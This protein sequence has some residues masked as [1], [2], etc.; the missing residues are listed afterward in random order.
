MADITGRLN[1]GGLVGW[2]TK[3]SEDS[4]ISLNQ[5]GNKG[6]VKSS[7]R[8]GGL[9]GCV[10]TNENMPITI[11]ECTNNGTVDGVSDSGGLIGSFYNNN[12]V[13]VS[14]VNSTNTGG[15]SNKNK[16]IGGFVGVFDHNPNIT[17]SVFG[18]TNT[19]TISGVSNAGGFFGDLF[20]NTHISLTLSDVMN[21]GPISGNSYSGGFVGIIQSS[22]P[23][24]STSLVIRN[25]V[26]KG[27]ITSSDII[28]CGIF[29][30]QGSTIFN[31]H[32]TVLNSI[33]KGTINV[34]NQGYGIANDVTKAH[35][36][37]SMGTING[38][39]TMYSFWSSSSEADELF[40][41]KDTCRNCTDG[42]PFRTTNKGYY[43]VDDTGE[44]VDDLLNDNAANALYGMTWTKELDLAY[45][46]FVFIGEPF[47][48]DYNIPL[49]STVER[50]AEIIG[51]DT[52]K[53]V[54]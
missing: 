52:N 9:I 23:T 40:V 46:V 33:N 10:T 12:N 41:L 47:G 4:F 44:Y 27:T 50:A 21:T 25:G 35:N 30:T 37:V 39:H 16:D 26:N 6:Y 31:T 15:V 42:K 48:Q 1:V 22:D 28:G 34:N 49:G 7:G 13:T 29:C 14:F 8:S 32:T 53:Y 45:V 5:C 19:G 38:Q 18:S 24:R 36:I 51:L 43:Q 2:I 20:D 3:G 54:Q 11:S 17:V